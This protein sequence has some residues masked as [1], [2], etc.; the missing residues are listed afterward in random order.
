MACETCATAF[1]VEIVAPGDPI[2][3]GREFLGCLFIC[4]TCGHQ[5]DVSEWRSSWV[6]GFFAANVVLVKFSPEGGD[7]MPSLDEIRASAVERWL[8]G[9]GFTKFSHYPAWDAHTPSDMLD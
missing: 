2:C 3:L 5:A 9:A 8:Q 4:L 1:P 7:V 6:T